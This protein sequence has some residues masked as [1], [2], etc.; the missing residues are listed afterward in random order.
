MA[1]SL[2]GE[3]MAG[4]GGDAFDS[5]M[6]VSYLANHSLDLDDVLPKT[7]AGIAERMFVDSITVLQATSGS[8]LVRAIWSAPGNGNHIQKHQA[9]NR[10]QFPLLCPNCCL[11]YDPDG[12]DTLP[13]HEIVPYLVAPRQVRGLFVPLVIDGFSMGRLDLLRYS[14]PSF[15]SSERSF[16][17]ACGRVLSLTLRNGM[18]YARVAWLA[19]HDPLTGIGNRRAFD[20]A[21]SR[22]ISRAQRY[23]RPLTLLLIDLDDFK[24]ANTNLG[25]SGG[26]EVLRRIAEVLKKGAR[27]GVD[28]PCRIGGDEFALILPEIGEPSAHELAQRLMSDVIRATT[29]LWPMHFSYSLATYPVVS[30]EDLRRSADRGLLDAKVR[31]RDALIPNLKVVQ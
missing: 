7:L 12:A 5:L 10:S 9:Y 27:Q 6:H 23:S 21:L 31:K 26:D 20:S 3:G 8:V 2:S 16:A 18:E 4:K 24:E 19:D 15:T 13:L 29:P 14:G 1:T 17:E 22:E 11:Q 30:A 28:V 25:L